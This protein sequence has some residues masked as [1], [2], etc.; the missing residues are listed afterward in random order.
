MSQR[1]KRASDVAIKHSESGGLLG[2]RKRW[3]VR[4]AEVNDMPTWSRSLTAG[5]SQVKREGGRAVV[6]S[7]EGCRG[8]E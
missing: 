8:V 1:E 4:G 2:K 7:S 6:S 3:G 5:C